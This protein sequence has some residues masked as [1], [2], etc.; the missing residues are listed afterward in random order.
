MKKNKKLEDE[1]IIEMCIALWKDGY[2]KDVIYF[3]LNII[4]MITVVGIFILV[5]FK[6]ISEVQ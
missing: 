2:K 6:F 3:I 4:G 5:F 1:N